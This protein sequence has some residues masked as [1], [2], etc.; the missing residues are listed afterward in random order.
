M[1]QRFILDENV[2]ICAQLAT[3]ERGERD[4]TC[5]SLVTQIIDI[6]HTLVLDPPLREK[7]LQQ[8]NRAPHV[9]PESG[10]VFLRVL[11][12]A[13]QRSGK[14]DFRNVSRAFPEE[15]EIP[16]GSQDD[17][18]LVRLAVESGAIL[19][20][21]DRPLIEDLNTCSV[22]EKYG[23]RVLLPNQALSDL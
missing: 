23:L 4:L 18:P 7:Y 12:Y 2:V 17:V 14:V 1:T 5:V 15:V 21:T 13:F 11:A 6:C 10:S 20:T 9:N 19:V 16:Q 22:Q 3:N 8:L